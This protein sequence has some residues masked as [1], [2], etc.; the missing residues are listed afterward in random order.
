MH[1]VLRRTATG[2]GTG[3]LAVSAFALAPGAAH[4]AQPLAAE[5]NAVAA[6]AATATTTSLKY[7][8]STTKG[9]F[10]IGLGTWAA[11]VTVTAPLTAARGATITAPSVGAAITVPSGTTSTLRLLGISSLTGSATVWYS[12]TGAVK[13]PGNRTTTVTV[14]TVKVPSSGSFPVS[15]TGGPIAETAASTAGTATFNIGA[16]VSTLKTNTGK[17][18]PI[19]CTPSAGQS[20][21]VLNVAVK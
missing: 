17:S 16:L 6:T 1:N 15:L 5:T 21:V 4:A 10:K 18:L 12:A 13:N 9:G 7:D 11:T 19:V 2:L 3:A 8:C 14:P 20:L